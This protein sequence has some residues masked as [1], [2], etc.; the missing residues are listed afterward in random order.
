MN[1]PT[2]QTQ[3]TVRTPPPGHPGDRILRQERINALLRDLEARRASISIRFGQDQEFFHSTLNRMDPS[4]GWLFLSEL[5]PYQGNLRMAAG[6]QVHVY[7]VLNASCLHF[8]AE[9]LH[10]GEHDGEAFYVVSMPAEL[11]SEQK[12]AHFRA[13]VD[14]ALGT[15]VTLVDRDGR[16]FNGNLADIS[17]GGLRAAFPIKTPIHARDLLTLSKLVLSGNEP[18]ECG[19]QIRFASDDRETGERLIGGRFYDLSQTDEQTLLR[20][21]LLMERERVHQNG[22]GHKGLYPPGQ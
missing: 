4:R 9:V 21:L 19:I 22:A 11:D 10:S 8:R 20:A 17:L 12:R 2:N 1:Q 3:T 16:H 13:P 5:S 6:Q 7:A 14:D 18:I 15:P